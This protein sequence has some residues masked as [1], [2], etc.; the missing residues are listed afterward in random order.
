[1]DFKTSMSTWPQDQ[2]IYQEWCW[3]VVLI[4][5]TSLDCGRLPKAW[6][7]AFITPLFKKGDRSKPANYRPVSLISI[8]CKLLEHIIHSTVISHLD[9]NGI[10]NGA[11]HGFRKKRSSR[12][13]LI[14][15]EII[16]V[17]INSWTLKLHLI[18]LMV[19]HFNL[20]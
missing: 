10:L 20:R 12:S 11:Q 4:F 14:L 7:E 18:K 19:K 9:E 15:A 2:I 6:K 5:Q 8:C 1:M 16:R 17:Q 3:K 13:Q